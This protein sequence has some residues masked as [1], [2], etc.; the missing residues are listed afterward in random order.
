[1]PDPGVNSASLWS[2]VQQSDTRLSVLEG[3]CGKP[4]EDKLLLL[5]KDVKVANVMA[6]GEAKKVRSLEAAQR[7]SSN[8]SDKTRLD[9]A[10]ALCAQLS[11]D[12][13]LLRDGLE[14]VS[15]FIVEMVDGRIPISGASQPITGTSGMVSTSIFHAHVAEQKRELALLN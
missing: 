14:D 15:N 2:G 11:R 5:Q 10:H 13:K 3:R 4:L 9:Q 1:M 6:G 8:S 12:N 7:L